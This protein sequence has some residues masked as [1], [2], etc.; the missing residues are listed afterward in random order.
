MGG[1]GSKVVNGG[2]KSNSEEGNYTK[3]IFLTSKKF[4][5]MLLEKILKIRT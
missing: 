5:M 2:S 1:Q 3:R 4:G